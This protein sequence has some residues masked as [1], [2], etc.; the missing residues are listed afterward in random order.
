M[1]SST[2]IPMPANDRDFEE[3]CAVLFAGLLKDP[4]VKTF[5][6][7]G[8]AQSGLDILGRRHRD[9]LQPVGV[10]CKLKT[11]GDRLTETEV[12]AEIRQA[13]AVT[14]ALTE[15]YIVTTASDDAKLDLLA[16]DLSA[17]QARLGRKI[18]IQ[19]WGWETL[20]RHIRND[21]NALKAFDPG[22]SAATDALLDIGTETLGAVEAVRHQVERQDDRFEEIRLLITANYDTSRGGSLEAH[23]DRQIDQY[24]DLLNAGKPRTA[25][26]LLEK[27]EQSLGTGASAAIRARAKANMGWAKIRLDD[28]VAGGK[29]LL[30]AYVLNP[31][32]AKTSANRIFG[33]VL[34]G[35]IDAALQHARQ[36]LGEDPANDVAASFVF[37]AATF[38]VDP[39]D[40]V[41]IVP[42]GLREVGRVQ[43]AE[44][45]YLRTKGDRAEWRALAAI[46]YAGQPDDELAQ[47]FAAEALLDE[48]FDTDLFEAGAVLVESKR[49][50]LRQGADLLQGLWQKTRDYEN[51]GSDAVI[52][53]GINLATAY[54][55]LGTPERALE[56]IKQLLERAP[57][58]QDARLAAAQVSIELN[59]AAATLEHIDL[60]DD[61]DPVAVLR[62]VALSRE[63]RWP[64]MLAFAEGLDR[65]AVDARDLSAIDGLIFRAK[66]TTAGPDEIRALGSALLEVWPDDVAAWVVVADATRWQG[67]ITSIDEAEALMREAATRL[68]ADT[69]YGSRV[70]LSNLAAGLEDP[71]TVIQA[72]DGYVPTTK[73]SERLLRLAWAFANAKPSPRIHAFFSELPQAILEIPAYARMAGYAESAR[74][75]LDDAER[76]LKVA[77]SGDPAD[78]RAHL[79]LH[80]VLLR[81][82]RAHDAADLVRAADE[83][84]MVGAPMDQMRWAYRLRRAAEGPRA[85]A[86]GYR[87]V[88][89]HRDDV[90]VCGA[91]P[92]LVLFDEDLDAIIGTP[93][94]DHLDTWF[95]LEG[96][97][98][99]DVRGVI[100]LGGDVGLDR[101]PPEHALVRAMR[102]KAVGDEVTLLHPIGP[103]RVYV[104]RALKPKYIWLLHEIMQSHA[105]RFPDASNLF[106][107]S[108]EDGDLQPLL[109]Y[110]KTVSDKQKKV[111]RIYAE[112]PVPLAAVAALSKIS[113]IE[114]GDSVAASG[115]DV[116]VC[117]G[118]DEERQSAVSSAHAAR[119]RGVVLDTLAAWTA[120]RLG[121]LEP[122]KTYFG[123]L[124]IP[125]SSIDELM[126]LREKKT[127]FLARD[128]V[129]LGY[130]Q[131]QPVQQAV[132]PEMTDTLV[133][134]VDGA[135]KALNAHCEIMPVDGADDLQIDNPA[136]DRFTAGNILDPIHLSR[137]H[138]LPLLSED[139]HL[140][141]WAEGKGAPAGFWLLAAAHALGQAKVIDDTAYCTAFGRLAFMRHGHMGLNPE[142]LVGI[143]TLTSQGDAM[144][145]AALEYLG[146][147]NAEIWSHIEAVVSFGPQVLRSSLDRGRALRS[148]TQCVERL[149]VGRDTVKSAIIFVVWYR[150]QR[151]AKS[152]NLA[153]RA[154]A[155]HLRA[156]CI[157]HFLQIDFNPTRPPDLSGLG[158]KPSS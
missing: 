126:E 140:R 120:Y 96:K 95:D 157:G 99:P 131:D 44:V 4:N 66:A 77:V 33:L 152:G 18:D 10:Q 30:Q 104:V 67:L 35:E 74:G 146:G 73:P 79:S 117:V 151:Q 53:I 141:Q 54:R 108:V 16:T 78:L 109:D 40:P 137:A 132:T 56:T 148:I 136:I 88:R 122:L 111:D 64:E 113:V 12:R 47:R 133:D 110:V 127:F 61:P 42:A 32:D 80:S 81:Q 124:V 50:L 153:A 84:Q 115:G 129:T 97:G 43:L 100:E 36:L 46:A 20:Q 57:R 150:W 45:N 92:A 22:Q 156:W 106:E 128:Y 93:D 116:R 15:Y 21:L 86:L 65:Q 24:R 114:F 70:M 135:I 59:D 49:E 154:A 48:A 6:T 158:A 19:V 98:V 28:D 23:Q 41:A 130:W 62:L 1:P 58:N 72:L 90:E 8:Q 103:K 9:P 37:Q 14:P 60:L 149:V 25:L 87:I 38:A 118:T 13:V 31:T 139:L 34:T 147:A 71:D 134:A 2:I 7:R 76:H 155:E 82:D 27:L 89:D 101:Y 138:N 17:E 143:L 144:F 29:L 39:V 52:G 142:V 11:K 121:L 119:G 51:G 112:L 94:G 125:R 102:E 63:E 75:A 3:H 123:R 91:Y 26:E 55:G 69:P 5:G 105:T 145:A 68:T 85:L 107:M 83:N